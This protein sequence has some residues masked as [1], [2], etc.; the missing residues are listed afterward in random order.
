MRLILSSMQ[1][2]V[3]PTPIKPDDTRM[4]IASFSRRHRSPHVQLHWRKHIVFTRTFRKKGTGRQD[5]AAPVTLNA[6]QC[7]LQ[8]RIEAD[9]AEPDYFGGRHKSRL[10]SELPPSAAAPGRTSACQHCQCALASGEADAGRSVAAPILQWRLPGRERWLRLGQRQVMQRIEDEGEAPPDG[11]RKLFVPAARNLPPT[12]PS[13]AATNLRSSS[14]RAMASLRGSRV[15]HAD[16]GR[17]G[18]Q[19][20]SSGAHRQHPPG[21]SRGTLLRHAGRAGMARDL[22][23]TASDKPLG[24]SRPSAA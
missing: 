8:D 9:R 18:Q 5:R 12:R 19:T 11:T 1:K 17:L 2:T 3:S 22:N 24:G 23:E 7:D 13:T 21:R 6:G 4:P 16:L 14:A 15:R 20:P 10:P